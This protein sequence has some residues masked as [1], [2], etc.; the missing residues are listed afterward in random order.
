MS[1]TNNKEIS[2]VQCW[3][4][5]RIIALS[6][7]TLT[8]NFDW[9]LRSIMLQLGLGLC[10]AKLFFV[11][12]GSCCSF[13]QENYVFEIG[14][15]RGEIVTCQQQ[16]FQRQGQQYCLGL[17][18]V[19]LLYVSCHTFKDSSAVWKDQIV[20]Y[21]M[22]LGCCEIYNSVGVGSFERWDVSRDH[23]LQ[24]LPHTFPL[25]QTNEATLRNRLV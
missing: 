1:K 19:W 23:Y 11:Y 7:W 12:Q 2:T 24:V 17:S 13:V 8:R 5:V 18:E 20:H 21:I 16:H 3:L 22:V 15:F 4:E 14:P 25:L 9:D 10:E 6:S